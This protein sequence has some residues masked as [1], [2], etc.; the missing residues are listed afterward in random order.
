MLVSRYIFEDISAVA[1]TNNVI[2]IMI[3][4][5]ENRPISMHTLSMAWIGNKCERMSGQSKILCN[6]EIRQ[7]GK[8]IRIIK[9]I[10]IVHVVT[11][12]IFHQVIDTFN[13][14]S[15]V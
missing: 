15:Q 5:S 13:Q 12:I 11:R 1:L 8:V 14:F 9:C 4:D 6:C 7:N 2:V 10:Q 3:S